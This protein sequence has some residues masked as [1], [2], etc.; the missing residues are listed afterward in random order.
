MV[1]NYDKM[2]MP[3]LRDDA[4]RVFSRSFPNSKLTNPNQG[5]EASWWKFWAKSD[6]K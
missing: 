5:G 1:L 2:N 6:K 4:K 3:E